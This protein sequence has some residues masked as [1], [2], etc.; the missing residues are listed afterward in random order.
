MTFCLAQND[1]LVGGGSQRDHSR[2]FP[3]QIL[4]CSGGE[5]ESFQETQAKTLPH[6]LMLVIFG[7][8]ICQT[9]CNFAN[10]DSSWNSEMQL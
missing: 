1:L 4:M 10:I 9:S 7:H 3:F 8:Q 5:K 6:M 2:A